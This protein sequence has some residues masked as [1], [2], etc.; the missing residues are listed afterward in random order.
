MEDDIL[1]EQFLRNTLS[2]EEHTSFLARMES[3]ASFK[4]QVRL[5][6]QL[7]HTLGDTYWSF[8]T[9][10]THKRVQ[11]Y[12][13]VLGSAET[14]QLKKTISAAITLYKNREVTTQKPSH[15]FKLRFILKIAALF[16]IFFSIFWY[17]SK[18]EKID[19]ASLTTKAWNKQVGLDFTLRSNSSDSI[20]MSLEKAL[21]FYTH[22][23]YDST[24]IVLEKYPISSNQYKDVLLM[25]A[26]A[27]YKLQRIETTFSTLDSLQTYSPDVANWYKGLIYLSQQNHEK[28]ALYL[29][30]P[31]EPDQEIKLKK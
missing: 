5:E 13:K 21:H 12:K 31:S 8:A 6:E 14:K 17:F 9:N 4:E 27:N 20:K 19:Y 2:D 26:L 22:K 30:I 16:V 7:L 24:L 28:A 1:I 29:V 18:D 25:R 3:D 15:I 10:D 23:K 11:A